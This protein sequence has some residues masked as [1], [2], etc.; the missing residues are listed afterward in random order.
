MARLRLAGHRNLTESLLSELLF[1]GPLAMMFTFFEQKDMCERT[2]D[3]FSMVSNIDNSWRIWQA[4]DLL[5]LCQLIFH[6]QKGQVH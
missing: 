6:G 3:F 4:S 1:L 2:C 5:N